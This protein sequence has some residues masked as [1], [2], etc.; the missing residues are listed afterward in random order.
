MNNHFFYGFYGNKRREIKYLYDEIKED[1]KGD[2]IKYIVEPYM[3]TCA[4]S[5]FIWYLYGNKFTYVLND[6]DPFLIELFELCKKEDEFNKFID[7]IDNIINNENYTKEKHNEYTSRRKGRVIDLTDYFIYHAY[8]GPRPGLYPID[9]NGKKKSF[10][11]EKIKNAPI[12]NFIKNANIILTEKEGL[13]IYKEYK[14]ND[15]CII[16]LDPPYKD[17][18]NEYTKSADNFYI[19]EYLYYNDIF[20]EKS[21]II[22]IIN[23]N[24][25][26]EAIFKNYIVNEY[27]I[28]YRFYT[29][30]KTKHML[31][32]NKKNNNIDK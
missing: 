16:F 25:M 27:Y 6:N 11:G 18:W 19:Y 1:L 7:N 32:S 30:K 8:H 14:N 31:I 2:K 4:L 13:E 20:L 17:V 10:S 26:M 5:Y 21:K 3:G 24:W 29:T 23:F 9:K 12:I 22:S 15:E 28:N